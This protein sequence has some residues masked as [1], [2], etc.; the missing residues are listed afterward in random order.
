M[1]NTTPSTTT[2][3]TRSDS[4]G[5]TSASSTPS[6]SHLHIEDKEK[7]RYEVFMDQLRIREQYKKKQREA[8]L[9]EKEMLKVRI[10]EENRLALEAK[11]KQRLKLEAEEKAIKAMDEHDDDELMV[12]EEMTNK[13]VCIGMVKTDIVVEK[14]PLML[15]RDDQYEI[16]TLESEGKLNTNN[17]CKPQFLEWVVCQKMN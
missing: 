15:I 7:T 13:N 8:E 4:S 12:D 5:N 10:A 17:Y 14:S 11:E 6:L 9:Q 16:V 2:S 1:L 3:P